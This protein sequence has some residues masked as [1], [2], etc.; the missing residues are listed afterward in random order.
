MRTYARKLIA[1]LLAVCLL[2]GVMPIAMAVGTPETSPIELEITA[3]KND[4]GVEVLYQAITWINADQADLVVANRNKAEKLKNLFF[5]CELND[6]LTQALPDGQ[7]LPSFYFSSA[8]IEEDSI[9][10]LFVS[11]GNPYVDHGSIILSYKLNPAAVDVF[12]TMDEAELKEQLMCPMGMSLMTDNRP[13]VPSET[14]GDVEALH[15]SAKIIMCNYDGS[16]LPFFQV[17]N[18][19]LAEGERESPINS[20]I[21][22]ESALLHDYEPFMEGYPDDTFKPDG[23]ITRAEVAQV[24]SR[25]VEAPAKK[26]AVSFPDVAADAWYAEA[27]TELAGMGYLKGGPDGTFRPD[28]PIT[29]AEMAALLVRFAQPAGEIGYVD[30]FVDVPE[31]HWAYEAIRQAAAYG[32]VNGVGEGRFSPDRPIT[33]AEAAKLFCVMMGR[34]P[35]KVAIAMGM[36]RE[37]ADVSADHWAYPYIADAST[38]RDA[39]KF[40]SFEIWTAAK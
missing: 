19:V 17:N 15:T 13:V 10:K 24:L 40:G 3:I 36:A 16:D 33:R 1:L 29:R 32:W 37:F 34:Y 2:A 11:A 30:D 12:P 31:S 26:A 9:Q 7:E 14:A 22:T 5:V 25:R 18:V 6:E 38:A 8:L 23:N 39:I 21:G 27:V 4:D 28:A 20:P 35:D